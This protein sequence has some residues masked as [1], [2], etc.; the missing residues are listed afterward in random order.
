MLGHRH[1]SGNGGDCLVEMMLS[2]AVISTPV[3]FIKPCIAFGSMMVDVEAAQTC[4]RN[5]DI[6]LSCRIL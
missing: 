1:A 3:E 5:N 6:A 4:G 2:V